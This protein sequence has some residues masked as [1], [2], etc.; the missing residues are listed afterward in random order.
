[1]VI[2][3]LAPFV[4]SFFIGAFLYKKPYFAIAVDPA[5]VPIYL[6]AL[7]SY[8]IP[9][10]IATSL[11]HIIF[12]KLSVV[13]HRFT[14]LQWYPLGLFLGFIAGAG[15]LEIFTNIFYKDHGSKTNNMA[16]ALT[17]ALT[18]MLCGFIIAF[19]WWNDRQVKE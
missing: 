6:Y 5:G 1:M 18:G 14:R 11:G 2:L 16:L 4:G 13:K 12:Y 15:T 17:G 10:I 3:F 19:T 7:I 9:V 8:S